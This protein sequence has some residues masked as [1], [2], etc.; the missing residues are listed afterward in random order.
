M[1]SL[2]QNKYMKGTLFQAGIIG[3]LVLSIVIAVLI[4]SGVIKLPGAKN[5]VQYS[6]TVTIWG[7]VRAEKMAEIIEAVNNQTKTYQVL[8]QEKDAATFEIDLVQA[9]ASQKGP[10][11]LIVQP[12]MIIKQNDKFEVT[13]FKSFSERDFKDLYVDIANLF[14]SPEG[15]L[16]FPI[17]VDPMVLYYNKD[18]FN[19]EAIAIPP[20]TW[21][22]L[23]ELAPRLSEVSP[24]GTLIKSMIAL[25]EFD[26]V[27]HAKDIVALLA[28]QLGNPIVESKKTNSDDGVIT[29]YKSVFNMS[30]EQ[31][32]QVGDSV[33]RF[34]T[35][36][37][38]PAKDTYT[39]NKN[40]PDSQT[41]FIAGKI[42][43]YIGYA[44]EYT[45]IAEK[46]P[47]LSFDITRIPQI[48]DYPT[49]TTIGSLLGVAI[50]TSSKN[51]GAAFDTT[52]YLTSSEYAPF[53]VEQLGT[54]PARRDLLSV[55]QSDSY[56]SVVY[57]SAII[58]KSWFDPDQ[59][60]TAVIFKKMITG[61][62]SGRYSIREA[63]NDF[64]QNLQDMLPS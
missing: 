16:A 22:E 31:G 10:D 55:K 50:L 35:S 49:K 25:G 20:A 30:N 34:Y 58:A 63:V 59:E 6:G 3:T 47:N 61:V 1:H 53:I 9:L 12:S 29:Q 40:I 5:S 21:N 57:P 38:D 48:K 15:I 37:S 4:F 52:Q 2:Q 27:T 33:L 62:V 13:P 26:N 64:V 32:V 28:L 24:D 18:I 41:Q 39:W 46:N 17:S 11:I 43:F 8:Y 23:I 51:K 14:L 44:S 7:T 45:A 42:P 19:R 60:K 56:N 36:F 54:A